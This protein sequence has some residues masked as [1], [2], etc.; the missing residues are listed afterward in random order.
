[1]EVHPRPL[2]L[3]DV[4]DYVERAFRPVA[5]E[6]GLTFARRDR[7]RRAGRRS[8][9]T[10]SACSRCCATCSPT[11]SSSPRRARSTLADR[12]RRPTAAV[13][14]RRSR[15]RD[16]G[17]GIP[18]DKLRLIFEAF[19][20][21]DG[22]TS[23]RYGGTGLGLSISREIA[24][25]LGGEIQVTST[26]GRGQR[27]HAA[28]CRR[29]STPAADE[30]PTSALGD[31][32]SARRRRAGRGRASR[33]ARSR[34]RRRADAGRARRRRDDREDLDAGDRVLLVVA[35]R[36]RRARPVERARAAGFKALVAHGGPAAL[37]ARARVRARRGRRSTSHA[38]SRRCS[39]A[40]SATRARATSRCT[41]RRRRGR[42]ARRRC[43]PA[44]RRS[45]SAGRAER[46]TR[47]WRTSATFLDRPVRQ[48]LVVEDDETSASAIA[49]LVGGEGVEVDRGRLERGGARPSSSA[50]RFDC[51]V[52]DLKLPED[53][54]FSC[55]SG[56]RT[57]SAT[58]TLPV[59]IHTGK[60]LTRREETRLQRY[61]ETIIV[62]DARSPER[63]LDETSL[64]LHRPSRAARRGPPAC[65]SSC[66]RPTRCSRAGRC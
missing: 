10:S 58:A 53:D 37:G 61:A 15:S 42:R 50:A 25:L 65:S 17:I 27:V 44:R 63:L 52:L 26:P 4:R 60:A 49:E 21:A 38:E 35:G 9:P 30:A 20:Q 55:S 14:G 59:I 2:P 39:S 46:S 54:G 24:R 64:F 8:S 40:S 19:Q 5:E 12:R 43:A 22:T 66:T 34:R 47:R 13:R 48:L 45:S 18:Q 33:C 11:R 31:A 29:R 56:S 57:T 7:R 1:M 6:K 16:T 23:R 32:R 36:R 28:A 51:M 3:A 41:S 62:K